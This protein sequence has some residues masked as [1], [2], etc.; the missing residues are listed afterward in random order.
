MYAKKDCK[1]C[2][3]DLTEALKYVQK[4]T[5]SI[6]Q[7]I[8]HMNAYQQKIGKHEQFFMLEDIHGVLISLLYVLQYTSHHAKSP[9]DIH[10]LRQTHNMVK[11][12]CTELKQITRIKCEFK[13]QTI[14]NN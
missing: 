1:N 7:T 11:K 14:Y 5:C 12:A 6:M 2:H 3:V 13:M 10:D 9:D 8:H 4:S